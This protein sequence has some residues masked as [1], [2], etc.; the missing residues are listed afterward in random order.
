MTARPTEGSL[1]VH[2]AIAAHLSEH[3]TPPTI[4]ELGKRLRVSSS[5][6]VSKVLARAERD[7]LVERRGPAGNAKA[8]VWWPVGWWP[9]R[10]EES[11]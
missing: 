11:A 9:Q 3:G 10:R 8:G 5:G 6:T 4:R 7:G 2:D 1:R